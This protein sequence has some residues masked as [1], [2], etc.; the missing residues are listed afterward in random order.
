MLRGFLQS[1]KGLLL[2]AVLLVSVVFGAEAK[3]VKI[4]GT[5]RD[6]SGKPI[7]MLSITQDY[8]TQDPKMG[9]YEIT[10]TNNS[11]EFIGYFEVSNPVYFIG[12]DGYEA[13]RTL[14]D[15]R[16]QDVVLT[17]DD[18]MN[19]VID[20]IQVATP[21]VTIPKKTKIKIVGD[22]MVIPMGVII[23]HAWFAK[24][25]RIMLVPLIKD[26]SAKA[27]ND[28]IFYL[29]PKVLDGEEYHMIDDRKFNYDSLT[30]PLSQYAI[31]QEHSDSTFKQIERARAK[32][33]GTPVQNNVYEDEAIR[34]ELI[35]K[36]KRVDVAKSFVY[37]WVDSI[38][39]NHNH[40]NFI[41]QI[42][43]SIEDYKRVLYVDTVEIA[44]G[45]SDPLRFFSY[46]LSGLPLRDAS[47]IPA[48]MTM[49]LNDVASVNIKFKMNSNAVDKNDS[50]SLASMN[51]IINH[52]KSLINNPD[53]EVKSLTINGVASPDGVYESNSVLADKR[54][55]FVQKEIKN[56]LS[57][58]K[59][60]NENVKYSSEVESWLVVA[61]E[62]EKLDSLG[63]TEAKHIRKIVAQF[64]DS[65]DNQWS[66]IRL[67]KRYKSVISREILP[68]LRKVEYDIEYVITRVRN[69]DEVAE[70]FA[71]NSLEE[72]KK[73]YSKDKTLYQIDLYTLLVASEGKDN[74]RDILEE[75]V[76][77]DPFFAIAVN[78]LAVLN[79]EDELYDAELLKPFV[80]KVTPN[81]IRYNQAI[82]LMRTN[83]FEAA[84]VLISGLPETPEFEYIRMLNDAHLGEYDRGLKYFSEKGGIE[85]VIF[86][87]AADKNSEAYIKVNE[88]PD[89]PNNAK[90]YYLKAL[91]AYQVSL[92]NQKRN[93]FNLEEEAR[94]E[95]VEWAVKSISVDPKMGEI[96][97]VDS[98]IIGLLPHIEKRKQDL[99]M[100]Q[101]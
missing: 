79:I 66:H 51:Q 53:A 97:K 75:V 25:R 59:I 9:Q 86:L 50:E 34:K 73:M 40:G 61:D 87:L 43:I 76:A 37:D 80:D 90:F 70:I 26:L 101:K 45:T 69:A 68:K 30:N 11:G 14:S 44:K 100:K 5:V 46:D 39:Y 6:Q 29:E 95:A 21:Y 23:E 72:L 3:K 83:E 16:N 33:S 67:M 8:D 2:L 63:Q 41:A 12:G 55:A 92:D 52:T 54:S 82:M 7:G 65:F 85:E 56:S 57:E 74:Y 38:K 17:D 62:L 49:P 89:E 10:R 94:D 84:D 77:I 15:S 27:G 18:I 20:D 64:P 96:M 78:D 1:S 91:C 93:E 48:P 36:G 4:Q 31:I 99:E 60:D 88:L 58:D 98:E 32:T 81:S 35:R 47:Y 22:H 42:R 71:D 13:I 28:S 24:D 19:N